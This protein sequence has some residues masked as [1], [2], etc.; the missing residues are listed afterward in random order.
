MSARLASYVLALL[1]LSASAT[2]IY[3]TRDK[4]G[5]WIYTDKRPAGPSEEVK[6]PPINTVPSNTNTAPLYPSQTATPNPDAIEPYQIAIISPRE[7][8]TIPPG[9]RDLAIAVHLN[10]PLEASHLLM[11]FI[12]G[13]LLEETQ[14]TSIVIQ[15]VHRGAHTLVVEAVDANGTSL[16]KSPEVVV[17]VIRPSLN[18]PLNAPSRPSPRP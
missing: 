11:Y 3:R 2:E 8:V 6:L 1:C 10:R 15:E 5:N 13:E 9:Q 18:S 14:S 7:N 17:N 16:G 12:N 4:D